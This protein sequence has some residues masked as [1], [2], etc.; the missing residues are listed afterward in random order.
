MLSKTN[1]FIYINFKKVLLIVGVAV[2]LFSMSYGCG[3]SGGSGSSSLTPARN[4][5]GTWKT[6]FAV[7]FYIKTDFCTTDGSLGL[8]ASEDRMVTFI[9]TAVAGNDT[10]VN[11]EQDFTSSNFTVINSCGGTGYV[12]DVSPSFYTGVITG[13]T[14][15][16]YD[17][18]NVQKGVFTFTTDLMQGTWDDSWCMVY[19]QEVYTETN[20]LKLIRQ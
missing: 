1:S 2:A 20:Q 13:T 10:K 3:N 4:I 9:I 17:S 6:T 8:V 14:L 7:P 11:I 18:S 16:L 15:V 5:V 19:C 12:P